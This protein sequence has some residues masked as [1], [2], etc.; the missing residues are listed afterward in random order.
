MIAK[1]FSDEI[2]KNDENAKYFSIDA[3]RNLKV[4]W[5]PLLTTNRTRHFDQV[6]LWDN[7]QDYSAFSCT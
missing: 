1:A 6:F 2:A 4:P 5:N 3:E 7:S